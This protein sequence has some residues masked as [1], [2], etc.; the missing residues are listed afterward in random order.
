[1]S[2]QHWCCMCLETS[3]GFWFTSLSYH[4]YSLYLLERKHIKTFFY[5]T[6]YLYS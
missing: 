3:D 1:M 6:K 2:Q 5:N 4:I